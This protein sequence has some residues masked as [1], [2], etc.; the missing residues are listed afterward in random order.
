MKK[1]VIQDKAFHL[2]SQER[3]GCHYILIRGIKSLNSRGMQWFHSFRLSA[4]TLS[5]HRRVG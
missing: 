5:G 1:L 3:R 4:Q 2:L